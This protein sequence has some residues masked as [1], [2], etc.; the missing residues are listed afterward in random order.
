MLE[1]LRRTYN[2]LRVRHAVKTAKRLHSQT[3][4]KYYI[5]QIGGKLRILTRIQIAYLVDSGVLHPRMRKD[6]YIRKYSLTV[7]E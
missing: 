4:K 2:Y 6:Y 1:I 3:G 5:L 7:I